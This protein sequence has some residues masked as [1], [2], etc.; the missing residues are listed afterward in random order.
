MLKQSWLSYPGKIGIQ[1][2]DH[3]RSCDIERMINQGLYQLEKLNR[4]WQTGVM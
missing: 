2:H 4:M 1:S 3:N